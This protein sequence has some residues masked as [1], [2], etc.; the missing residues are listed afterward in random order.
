MTLLLL[1]LLLLFDCSH[2]AH[3]L[4]HTSACFFRYVGQLHGR[5][6]GEV[7]VVFMEPAAVPAVSRKLAAQALHDVKLASARFKQVRDERVGR[8]VCV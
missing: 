7:R 4:H 6:E 2:K 5:V 8:S 3:P 1:L